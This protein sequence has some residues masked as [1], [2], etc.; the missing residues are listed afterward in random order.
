MSNWVD[1]LVG[2]FSPAAGLI[3]HY[4]RQMLTRAYE[5]ASRVDG[6]R[7]KRAGA[8]AN[9]DHAADAGELR[10]RSRS[11]YQNV[12]YVARGAS[13]H[14]ANVIG[15][16]IVPRWIGD[17]AETYRKLWEAWAPMA[18]ADGRLDIYG[19]Q[20][21]VHAAAQR[22][23]EVLI[24]IRTRRPDDGLPVPLQL[25][26]LEIDW[27]D[28]SKM[29]VIAGET[30][31]NGIAYDVL[32]KVAGYYLFDQHPGEW[33]NLRGR[34]AD[35]RRVPAALIIH[36]FHPERPGQG[37]GFPR[38]APVI[39]RIRDFSLYEDAERNRKNLEARLGV[40]AMGDVASMAGPP[41][42]A[43]T[44][45]GPSSQEPRSLGELPSGAVMQLPSATS[46]E[47]VQP[48]AVPGYVEN[49]KLELHLIA[50]GAGWTYEMMTGDVR[51]VNFSSARIRL[52]DYRREA[53]REQWLCV[54]PLLVA[55]IVG[56]FVDHCEMANLVRRRNVNV[57]YATPKFDYVNPADDVKA[58]TAEVAAGLSSLSEKLRARG[59]EPQEVFEEI[60]ADFKKLEEL[61]VMPYLLALQKGSPLDNPAAAAVP[62][63]K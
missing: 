18:D 38:L 9:S 56:A 3:R 53:T 59:Y 11:L 33:V 55:R 4:Q 48:Q 34:R 62:K 39:A 23:G 40:L 8:S 30:V 61:G 37:R 42:G 50:A 15:T 60:S 1:R 2:H 43:A 31:V 7:P 13:S 10:S 22:D 27:L 29:G 58:D 5:G 12:P 51:E 44:G 14:T 19:I 45:N 47:V 6:W 46:V 25:Q 20:D 35:S 16:G 63:S 49:A 17:E 52:L 26:V 28:S 21:L 32:G 54:I 41:L 36:Y 57:R 24:R